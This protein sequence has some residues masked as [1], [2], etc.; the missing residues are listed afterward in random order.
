MKWTMTKHFLFSLMVASLLSSP[1]EAEIKVKWLD[2]KAVAIAHL[3]SDKNCSPRTI[4]GVI[5]KRDF[6]SDGV[7]LRNFVYEEKD[8]SRGIINVDIPSGE[9]MATIS[10][11]YP[12]LQQ[13]TKVGRAFTADVLACGAAERTLFLENLS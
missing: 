11:V 2:G 8:G 5:M 7:T 1:V 10:A 9:G 3:F 12:A 13:L 6:E 4:R